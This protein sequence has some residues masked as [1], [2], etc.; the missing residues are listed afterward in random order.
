MITFTIYGIPLKAVTTNLLLRY[1]NDDSRTGERVMSF[2]EE[3]AQVVA[4]SFYEKVP[5]TYGEEQD[6]CS[7]C[8]A[9]FTDDNHHHAS[10]TGCDNCVEAGLTHCLCCDMEHDLYYLADKYNIV[11]RS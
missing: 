2:V 7:I 5:E 11:I 4:E 9:K 3:C 1:A 8:G 10:T 6:E